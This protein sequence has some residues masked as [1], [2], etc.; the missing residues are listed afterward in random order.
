MI[1]TP[2]C[3]NCLFGRTDVDSGMICRRYPPQPQFMDRFAGVVGAAEQ[4]IPVIAFTVTAG[5]EWCGEYERDYVK[6]REELRGD[7]ADE[8]ADDGTA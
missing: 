5:D 3:S 7:G 4:F 6:S 2:R 8:G 1:P